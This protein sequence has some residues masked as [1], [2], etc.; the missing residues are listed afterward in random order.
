M[1]HA[2]LWFGMAGLTVVLE[3]ATGTFYLLMVALGMLAGGLV[4]LAGWDWPW[5]LVAAAVVAA[6]A[7][8]ALRRSRFGRRVKADVTRDPDANLDIGQRLHVDAW[9]DGGLARVMYR[10]AEWDIEL[11]P[12]QTPHAGWFEIREV[13]G[14]RLFVAEAAGA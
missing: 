10:G 4:A 1:E 12:G 13:R 6:V 9:K 3:L 14:N 11:L 5:Q 7:V 2:L 8:G